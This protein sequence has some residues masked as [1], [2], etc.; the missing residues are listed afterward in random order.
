MWKLFSIVLL[1]TLTA[2]AQQQ[3]AEVPKPPAPGAA[4]PAPVSAD[5]Y[6]EKWTSTE[7]KT[8][9]EEQIKWTK[10]VYEA[11]QRNE[12]WKAIMTKLDRGNNWLVRIDETRIARYRGFYF[13]FEIIK[14]R[15]NEI[16]PARNGAQVNA[17]RIVKKVTNGEKS[18]VVDTPLALAI[19]MSVK[20]RKNNGLL[21]L[22]SQPDIALSWDLPDGDA[23]AKDADIFDGKKAAPLQRVVA[24]N[25]LFYAAMGPAD[26]PGKHR[27]VLIR[28]THPDDERKELEELVWILFEKNL[29]NVNDKDYFDKTPQQAFEWLIKGWT[30]GGLQLTN[31]ERLHYQRILDVFAEAARRSDYRRTLLRDQRA[32]GM[33][34]AILIWPEGVDPLDPNDAPLDAD[35]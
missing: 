9:T 29:A 22:L 26:L 19:R 28:S 2:Q 31:V 4:A 1:F 5:S 6:D 12:P 18:V 23:I 27:T 35:N 21:A 30:A 20:E 24:L 17:V 11:I 15:A 25:E 8:F 16:L 13:G 33:T 34:D 14:W 7:G 10:A 32:K 3:P